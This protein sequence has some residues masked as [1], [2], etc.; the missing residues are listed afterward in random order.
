MFVES[1]PADTGMLFVYES[2]EPVA[3]WMKNTVLSLDMLFVRRNGE[4]ESIAARTTPGS[5][6]S[7]RSK[8]EVCCVLELPAGTAE[9]LAIE[10]GD[11]LQHPA[12]VP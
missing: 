9:R 11:R 3:M 12:F 6:K 7:L 5:L 1:L 8:G 2:S 10:P 4:I